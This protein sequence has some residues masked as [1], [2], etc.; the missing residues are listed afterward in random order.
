MSGWM[1][2]LRLNETENIK[3][4]V[5]FFLFSNFLH[6]CRMYK[7]YFKI[8]VFKYNKRQRLSPNSITSICCR[9]VVQQVVQQ[10]HNKSK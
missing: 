3:R 2:S 6:L 8:S 9:F 1:A 5:T 4:K 10:I 7:M